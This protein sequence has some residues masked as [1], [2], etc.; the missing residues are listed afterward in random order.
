MIG[1]L[2]LL[3]KIR[4]FADTLQFLHFSITEQY[5]NADMTLTIYGLIYN[6]LKQ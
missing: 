6:K 1:V 2:L 4:N 5:P 3:Q